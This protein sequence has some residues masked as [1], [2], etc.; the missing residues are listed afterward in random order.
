M[1]DA[2][3]TAEGW[4]ALHDFRTVDWDAWREAPER[5][6]E[7]ALSEATEFL[8]AREALAD[9]EAGDS[10][11]F[12][13]L[14]HEAD[15]CFVHFRPTLDALNR[16][17]RA[18]EGTSFAAYTERTYSYVSVT[19]VSGYVS[20]EYFEDPESVDAGLRR[21][22]EGKLTPEIPDD[23][24]LSFYPMSKRRDPEY[25]WYDL[26]FEERADLMSGH[27]NVGREFAGRIRQVIASSVG[28]DDWE[29]G[30]TLFGDDPVD[31]KDVV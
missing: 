31:V 26:P 2:P 22:I 28:L 5:D 7:S 29:W 27:G 1:V 15:L 11:T 14:G 9:A 20:D 30:V 17:E 23:T 4:Y 13:V 6:R 25:N 21:Y 8:A 12:A 18:F 16:I 19:E 24:Y 10:A 3:K